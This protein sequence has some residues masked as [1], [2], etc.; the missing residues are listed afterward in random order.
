LVEKSGNRDVHSFLEELDK[1]YEGRI[2]ARA[3]EE[4]LID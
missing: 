3:P 1:K 2:S 4:I